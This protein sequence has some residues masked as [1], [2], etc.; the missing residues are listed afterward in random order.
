METAADGRSRVCSNLRSVVVSTRG[1][2]VCWQRWRATEKLVIDVASV[3]GLGDVVGCASEGLF[4]HN[5][6]SELLLAFVVFGY[7]HLPNQ[8][9]A[10]SSFVL[11][12][13][14]DTPKE[15]EAA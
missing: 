2:I 6:A 4:A 15:P 12:L 13:D 11:A 9:L 8:G 14:L 1:C 3:G 10:A 7:E 5:L